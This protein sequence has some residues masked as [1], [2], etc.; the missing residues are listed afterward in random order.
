MPVK[1]I[2]NLMSDLKNGA[3]SIYINRDRKDVFVRDIINNT[4]HYDTKNTLKISDFC[5]T[6]THYKGKGWVTTNDLKKDFPKIYGQTPCNA[7][8]FVMLIKKYYPSS[9]LLGM[10]RKGS[11][12]K[13]EYK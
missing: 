12:Y 2:N 1:I 9:I 11:P 5:D 7:T 4:I 3:V 6:F 13:I 8:L 10:G